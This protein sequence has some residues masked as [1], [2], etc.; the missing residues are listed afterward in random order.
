[1]PE[2]RV[3]PWT[4]Q[5]LQWTR[6]PGW[7]S[8]LWELARP[9]T[10]IAPALGFL[11]GGLTALGA[12]PPQPLDW[13]HLRFILLGSLMAAVLNAGSNVL[14]Q[15]YDLDIDRINKPHRPL[16]SGRVP[17]GV[18]KAYAGFL[19]AAGL[20]LAWW[21]QPLGRPECFALAAAA[22]GMT[23]MYSAPPLRT[24]R[25]GIWA[26]V[27][28]AI[29]R[30]WLL[31]VA[32]WSSAKTIWGWEPWYIG[33]IFGLFLLGA[34]STKDFADIEGDRAYGCRTLPV[35]YGVRRAAQIISPFFIVPFLLIP[36][37]VRAGILTGNAHLL[38]AL[39]VVLV[40]YGA[41]VV[42]LMLRRPDELATDAN[43]ISWTHMYIMMFVAQVGFAVAYL[44]HGG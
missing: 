39:S 28:I 7:G 43:H 22:V 26:N 14:N 25:F 29:P 8:A 4:S 27:T 34:T 23:W 31:K 3:A 11:S 44:V 10:L 15:V 17:L 37:G 16:P 36:V 41:Y 6:R 18:A 20:V 38:D 30:G 5:V 13:A 12:R 35:R 21:V 1:M 42:Y 24:K 33:T 32:G 19:L 2:L 9:F 40:A